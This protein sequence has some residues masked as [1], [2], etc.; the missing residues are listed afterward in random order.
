MEQVV[1]GRYRVGRKIGSGAFGQIYSA[2]DEH[3]QQQVAIKFE[4]VWVNNPYLYF[5]SKMYNYLGGN[6]MFPRVRWYGR[7]GKHFTLVMDLLGDS[8]ESLFRRC[9][10]RLSLKT[11]LMLADQ[12]LNIIEYMHSKSYVHRD[13]KPANFVMG[14]G[15][16]SSQVFLIDF[17]LAKK[18][19]DTNTLEHF[20]Y[21][22]QEGL[23]GTAKFAS[24]NA[25]DGIEITRRDDLESLGYVLIYFLRGSLPWENVIGSTSNYVFQKIRDRKVK[26]NIEMLCHGLPLEFKNYL[27][28]VHALRF[29]ETP[30]YTFLKNMFRNL[31]ARQGYRHDYVFDWTYQHLTSSRS[32]G[33][34]AGQHMP[35]LNP[36]RFMH[37][38]PAACS[39]GRKKKGAWSKVKKFFNSL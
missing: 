26:T 38:D 2:I 37:G 11:V 21:R 32:S 15:D 34:P 27:R 4:S 22:E 30:D 7:S 16:R 25:H 9:G 20:P 39:Y 17:G 10:G 14:L 35:R 33:P 24:I 36:G 12:M 19:R 31:F 1:A 18:F 6:G 29:D 8:L 28:Y 3:T 5:E 23:T 13:I